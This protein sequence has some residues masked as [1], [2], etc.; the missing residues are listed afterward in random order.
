[1]KIAELRHFIK[2]QHKV[3]TSDDMGGFT[4]TW[5]TYKEMMAAIWPV[6]SKE[7]RENM[8][9]NSSTTHN[10]RIRYTPGITSKMKINFNDRVFD[11][12]G[13]LNPD[14]K[15]QWLDLVCDEQY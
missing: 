7:L 5:E 14:E 2:F 15:N 3:Q 13:I 12:Q 4:H 10:I 6:S 11:I 8:R 1:M 9:M